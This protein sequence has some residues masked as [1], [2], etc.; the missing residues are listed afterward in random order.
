[1]RQVRAHLLDEYVMDGL[2]ASPQWG[3][4]LHLYYYTHVN[5]WVHSLLFC[6][7]FDF[8]REITMRKL[9]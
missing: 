3:V 8:V 2:H 5:F 4:S 1:M 7:D 6:G 9:A